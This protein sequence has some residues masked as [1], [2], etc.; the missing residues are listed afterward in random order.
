V[1]FSYQCLR[2]FLT[3]AF[4]IEGSV[5]FLLNF[6]KICAYI[7]DVSEENISILGGHNIGHSK[8]KSVYVH[9]SYSERF[10][11]YNCISLYNSKIVDKKEILLTV[12]N[13][14]IYCSSDNVS[15]VYLV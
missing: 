6:V 3:S 11:K 14:G 1:K 5:C 15:T 9:V 7:Q 8:Q 10:P 2:T 4:F 13:T 12:S